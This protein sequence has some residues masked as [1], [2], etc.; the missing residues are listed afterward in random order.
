M[1]SK[2]IIPS[3][4][5]FIVSE[6]YRQAQ[7]ILGPL[8]VSTPVGFSIGASCRAKTRVTVVT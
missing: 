6:P 7:S 3:Q 8:G 5:A 4:E 1:N 2:W